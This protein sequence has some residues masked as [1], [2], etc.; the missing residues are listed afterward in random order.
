MLSLF[1]AVHKRNESVALANRFGA[2]VLSAVRSTSA[3]SLPLAHFKRGPLSV[4]PS[5]I[6]ARVPVKTLA[7][8][9][10]LVEHTRLQ[11]LAVSSSIL[12]QS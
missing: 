2:Q 4:I 11:D 7:V 12:Q 3:S 9:C 5:V 8:K 6:T 10:P 1:W